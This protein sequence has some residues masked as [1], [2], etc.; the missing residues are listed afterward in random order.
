MLKTLLFIY[1]IFPF[2]A[3]I[4]V[5]IDAENNYNSG[6]MW[7]IAIWFFFPIA[8]PAYLIISFRDKQTVKHSKVDRADDIGYRAMYTSRKYQKPE[9]TSSYGSSTKSDPDFVDEELEKLIR[10]GKLS[11]ARLYLKDML[12][13]AR[14]M[15]DELMQANYRRYEARITELGRKNKLGGSS[16]KSEE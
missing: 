12:D 7:A 4:W 9:Y 8:L 1:M 10:F 3:T 11:E 2:L 16:R 14:E 6:C 15:N 5:Y 13:V